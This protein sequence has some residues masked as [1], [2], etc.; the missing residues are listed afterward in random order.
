VTRNRPGVYLTIMTRAVG[1]VGDAV[2]RRAEQV[3]VQK[4][5]L[6]PT[7][8]RSASMSRAL[9]GDQLGRVAGPDL[10]V[11]V[12]SRRVGLFRR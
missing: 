7:T 1:M 4:V 2:G 10:D 5:P 9:A 8:T 6:W 3:V 11:E 12:D